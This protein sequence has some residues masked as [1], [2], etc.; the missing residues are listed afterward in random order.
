[1]W[2]RVWTTFTTAFIGGFA[3][4]ESAGLVTEGVE[5]TWSHWWRQLLGQLEPCR[6]STAGRVVIVAFCAWLAA[7]LGWG[8]FG[9]APRRPRHIRS[10]TQESK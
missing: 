7:H 3:L 9:V 1:M 5:G 8:R 2:W 10:N 4:L 6:H